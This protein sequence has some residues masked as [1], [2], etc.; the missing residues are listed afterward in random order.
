MKK[1]LL[2]ISAAVTFFVVAKFLWVKS[3]TNGQGSFETEK[4]EIIRRANYLTSKVNTSPRQ[5]L[6]EMPSGIG[7][8]FQGEWALYPGCWI[9]WPGAATRTNSCAASR[10]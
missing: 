9:C 7:P 4:N 8:Q 6:D 3:A 10:A 5:L 1:I 2:V